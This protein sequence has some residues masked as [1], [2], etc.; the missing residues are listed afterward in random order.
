M[1]L[2]DRYDLVQT[3]GYPVGTEFHKRRVAINDFLRAQKI[4]DHILMVGD[5]TV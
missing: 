2:Y 1:T 3:L 5:P 4:K